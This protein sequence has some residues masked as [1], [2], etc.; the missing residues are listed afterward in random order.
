[1]Q[2]T[3][4]HIHALRAI[5][6]HD[7]CGKWD[8]SVHRNTNTVKVIINKY[9]V[10]NKCRADVIQLYTCRQTEANKYVYKYP[11]ICNTSVLVLLQ[12]HYMFRALSA[13]FVISTITAV[14]SH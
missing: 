11:T 10:N 6:T 1:M 14:D 2:I 4:A 3:P 12:D 8:N 9:I 7:L 5:R 13:P